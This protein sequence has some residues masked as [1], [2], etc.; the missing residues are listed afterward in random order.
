MKAHTIRRMPETEAWD[1]EMIKSMKGTVQDPS[2]LWDGEVV[3]GEPGEM[4]EGK[5]T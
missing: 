2:G 1:G 5:Y 4:L 3:P